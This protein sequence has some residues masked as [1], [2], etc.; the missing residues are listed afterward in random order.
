[1]RKRRGGTAWQRKLYLARFAV[2]LPFSTEQFFAVFREYNEA[3]WPLQVLLVLLALCA[4]ALIPIKRAWADHVISGVLSF[5]WIWVGVV[6]HV[7]FFAPINALAYA[8]AALSLAGAVLFLWSSVRG[9]LR[10]EWRRNVRS[11]IGAL[12]IVFALIVYPL[13]S[14]MTGHGYPLMPTFGLPCPTTIFTIGVLAF[15]VAPYPRMVLAVPIVWC[16]I[17]SQA[18]VLLAVPQDL[19]LVVAGVIA[20]ALAVRNGGVA[21][22]TCS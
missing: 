22:P 16:L 19:G 5:L 17:G 21:H 2:K 3:V 1:M 8:F 13:W 9:Q 14:W 18:A 7:V 15:L 6:Y 12:L 4:I 11:G 20:I 10:F